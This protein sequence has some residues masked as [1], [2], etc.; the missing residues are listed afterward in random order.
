[1]SAYQKVLLAIDFSDSAA[2][3]AQ[4]AREQ[5]GADAQL[6][7]VHVIE[8]VPPVDPGY[9]PAGSAT[10]FIDD[11]EL[12]KV[13]RKRLDALL[14]EWGM[15]DCPHAIVFGRAGEEIV[16]QAEAQG[17]DLIV[18][19]SHGRHG[20]GLLLGSTANAVLHHARCDVL[21]VRV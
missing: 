7:V 20:L 8:Y 4:R 6:S 10:W 3:V 1:M 16:A 14:T 12:E 17:T 21:A 15:Q 13:A 9:D 2:Q 19:G 18:L 11:E 5:A